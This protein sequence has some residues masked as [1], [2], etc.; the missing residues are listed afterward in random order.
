MKKWYAVLGD[1]VSHSKSPAMHEHWF[2]ENAIDASYIPVHVPAG[3][4][5]EAV[6][7]LR[8]LGASGWNVTVPHKQAII[9]FLDELDPLAEAMQAVNT[10]RVMPDGRLRGSNTD[11]PGFVRSL[12]QAAG[13][14]AKEERVLIVGAGGAASGIALALMQEGYRHV[15]VCNRTVGKAEHIT[16]KTGGEALSLTE[17]EERLGEYRIIIQTTPVGMSTARAGLPLGMQNLSPDALVADIVYSP[18]HTEFLKAA[19]ANGN[20]IVD[21]LG[22]FIFQGALAFR[23]WTGILPDT[24]KMRERLMREMGYSDVEGKTKELSEK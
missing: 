15:S 21:G 10:V 22:M 17:A 4:I 12:E 19:M 3:E 11:G 16:G 5:G 14:A 2:G 23:E 20:R 6:R 7:S 13:P 9:P 1:P 8:T 24:E 18:L